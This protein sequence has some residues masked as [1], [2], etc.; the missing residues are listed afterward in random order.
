MTNTRQNNH[1]DQTQRYLEQAD[2]EI[3]LSEIIGILID[4]KW[5]IAL[6]TCITL[7]LGIF[8][9]IFS[10]P[11]YRA[12][13]MLQ[14][15]EQSQTI[16]GID[17]LELL[18]T[19]KPI[20]AEVQLIESRM[21]LGEVINNLN[22]EINALPRYFP[23]IGKTFVRKYQAKR[24][25]ASIPNTPF[26]GLSQYAWGGEAIKVETF[27]IPDDL[28]EEDFILKA[29]KEGAFELFYNDELILDGRVGELSTKQLANRPDSINLF[30]SQLRTRPDTEFVI[31]KQSK[32]TAI[33]FLRDHLTVKEKSKGT[34]ILALTFN[35]SNP[36]FA[37]KILNE[38]ANIYVRQNVEYKSAESKKTLAF[39]E[40]QLPVLKEQLDSAT[41]VLNDYRNQKGSINLGIET[42]QILKGIVEIKTK[43]TLLQ[44]ERDELRQK[45]TPSHPTIVGLDK[46]I[47]RLN[48]QLKEQNIAVKAL[49]DTQQV[50]LELSGDV[51]VTAELYKALLNN[52]QTLRVSNAGTVGDVRIIDY[53]ILPS[54]P[55]KPRKLLII[56]IAA[57][58]GLFLG[59]MTVFI[60]KSLN[61]GIED[62]DLIEKEL[63]IPVYATIAYSDS[64][65][66]LNNRLEKSNPTSL[67]TH[68]LAIDY[69]D[70]LAIESFRSLRTTLHFSLLE[71]KNNIILITG[72][73]P[74]VGKSFVS[75]NLATIMADAGKKILLIDG[76]MRK[77][78]IYKS[79]GIKKKNGLSEVILSTISIEEAIHKIPL[80]N[81]DFISTGT[82]PPNPSE[83]LLHEQFN[84]LLENISKQYDLVIIDS[85]PILAVTDAAI[86]GRV[87][88]AT[89]MVVQ[90]GTHPLRELEQSVRRL[91]QAGV[92]LKG[93]IF[94][95]VPK[96]SSRST[97]YGGNQYIYQYNYKK[98]TT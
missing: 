64:Q 77:G 80:A 82:F 57:V 58:I 47:T 93:I 38:I 53:A 43:V 94:N 24:E 70:D 74:N 35:S 84:I 30:V 41:K 78:T 31:Q 87:A 55:V 11:V 29:S 56:S 85:P 8:I 96:T 44:Q 26:L 39:L 92:D 95:G 25:N 89:F 73:S 97:G 86:M 91:T 50:I 15:N 72:P 98:S 10:T 81:I 42:Q 40:K 7:L 27:T 32:N 54:E 52:T 16:T 28:L 20:M 69:K 79:L 61:R 17:T 67:Q 76:D 45:Y 9:A 36:D 5:L 49:P 83:L 13:V 68:I 22:L 34:G 12:D 3:N 90:S 4:G 1:S 66:I 71:A 46:Q 21:I 18:S 65:K 37:V 14:V 75:V 62:P 6:I 59:G 51:R 63:N 48:Q 88:S 2:D 60:S 19:E 23:I 33:N